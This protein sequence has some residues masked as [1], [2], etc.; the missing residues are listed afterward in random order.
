MLDA[1]NEGGDIQPLRDT[2]D[3]V[4]GTGPK[5]EPIKQYDDPRIVRLAE[6]TR[7]GVSI[8]T[9]VF[10]GA[11]EADINEHARAGRSERFGTVNAL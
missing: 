5:G 3:S 11:V 4:I 2:I 9:P 6:Q 8:A 10:D 7:R 1:Y